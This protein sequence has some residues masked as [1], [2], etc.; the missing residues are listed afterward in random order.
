MVPYWISLSAMAGNANNEDENQLSS[1]ISVGDVNAITVPDDIF[2]SIQRATSALSKIY[3]DL[4][5]NSKNEF[6]SELSNNCDVKELRYVRDMMYPMVKR[7][8]S[9]GQLG[10]LVDRKSGDNLKERLIKIFTI[11]I[12]LVKGIFQPCPNTCLSLTQNL[13]ICVYKLIVV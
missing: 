3:T 12:Y 5:V 6:M 10:L 13:S 1:V 2:L 8:T 7:H 9:A 4:F 11:F